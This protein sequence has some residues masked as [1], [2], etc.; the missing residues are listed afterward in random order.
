M[1]YKIDV[2]RIR[3]NSI[4]LNGWAIGRSPESRATFRV[5]DGKHQ[6]VIRRSMTGS[7]VLISSFPMSGGKATIC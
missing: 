5:E 4:T 7:L 2:V 6:P 1:K 3:E